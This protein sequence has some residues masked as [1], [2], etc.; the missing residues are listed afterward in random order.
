MSDTPRRRGRPPKIMAATKDRL[1]ELTARERALAI[2]STQRKKV[3]VSLTLDEYEA[4]VVEAEQF[5]EKVATVVRACIKKGLEHYTRFAPDNRSPYV[6]GDLRQR[7]QH[8]IDPEGTGWPPTFAN[9]P[10]APQWTSPELPP[11]GRYSMNN[12]PAGL[13]PSGATISNSTAETPDTPPEIPEQALLE[14]E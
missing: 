4:I 12:I 11:V 7:P 6:D 9:I 5:N 2:R 13:L 1:S 10:L 14:I 8:R 3:M